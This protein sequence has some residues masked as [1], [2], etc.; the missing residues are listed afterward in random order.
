VAYGSQFLAVIAVLKQMS[1]GNYESVTVTVEV[2]LLHGRR[3]S[4]MMGEHCTIDIYG[5]PWQVVQVGLDAVISTDARCGLKVE[6]REP[7][8]DADRFT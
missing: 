7:M 8:D 3:R 1:Q 4:P 5:R 2:R 6:L